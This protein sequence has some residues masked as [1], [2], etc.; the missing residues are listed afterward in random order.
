MSVRTR[1]RE[2][3]RAADALAVGDLRAR[4]DCGHDALATHFSARQ[5]QL[6]VIDQQAVAGLYRF[7]DF[8]MREIDAFASPGTSL[9]SSVNVWPAFS[10]DVV[11]ANLPTRSFGPWRSAR[12]PIGRHSGLDTADALKPACASDHGWHGSC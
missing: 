1:L 6:A 11:S 2:W 7:Q 12:M 10:L 5:M 8:R 4:D 3:C 9:L